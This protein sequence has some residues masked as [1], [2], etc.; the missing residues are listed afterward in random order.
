MPISLYAIMVLP[1]M[2]VVGGKGGLQTSVVMASRPV[3]A[4]LFLIYAEHRSLHTY[5]LTKHSLKR[6]L[7]LCTDQLTKLYSPCNW[8]S[9]LR[10][11]NTVLPPDKLVKS[12]S[13]GCLAEGQRPRQQ[14]PLI[15]STR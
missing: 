8:P 14:L 15:C 6:H 10:G 5:T 3:L 11:A 2:R 13:L 7:L 1:L 4:I 9:A 12:K